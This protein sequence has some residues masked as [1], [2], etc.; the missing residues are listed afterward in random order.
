MAFSRKSTDRLLFCL[1]SI[2]QGRRIAD[3]LFSI[4]PVRPVPS[5]G[6][7]MAVLV[8]LCSVS[9]SL[10]LRRVDCVKYWSRNEERWGHFTYT[11]HSSCGDVI[12]K[13]HDLLVVWKVFDNGK[14]VD[15]KTL[16]LAWQVKSNIYNNLCAIDHKSAAPGR[17]LARPCIRQPRML[18]RICG[19]R[20]TA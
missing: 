16:V 9:D 7:S 14:R 19:R 11:S 1:F 18:A 15:P 17:R 13:K 3:L 10:S 2:D 4:H 12:N 6:A 20:R 8:L 5:S